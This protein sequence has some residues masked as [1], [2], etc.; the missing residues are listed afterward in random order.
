[1]YYN[2]GFKVFYKKQQPLFFI[3]LALFALSMDNNGSF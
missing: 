1:M 2:K 3:A